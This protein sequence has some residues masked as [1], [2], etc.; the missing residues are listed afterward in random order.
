MSQQHEPLPRSAVQRPALPTDPSALPALP[1]AYHETLAAGLDELSIGLSPEQLGSLEGHVRLLLAWTAA[2]NLTAIREPVAVAREHLL[3]SLTAVPLLAGIGATSMLDLGSGGGA[4]G[5]PLAIAVPAS[6]VLLV[7]SV[8]KKAAFL[9][10][11]TAALGLDSRVGVA[12]ER[13]EAIAVDGRERGR[14]QV[15]LARAVASLG[16]L[17][18]LSFPL[19]VPG[20]HLVAWKRGDLGAEL[21]GARSAAAAL[22][23]GEL[24]VREVGLAALSDHRLVVARRSGRVPRRFPRP[25]AERAAKGW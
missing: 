7:E 9:R 5:I 13:A 19:L 25:P 3:D 8:G 22:G 2:I 11:A 24:E 16:D 4:P 6:R 1:S 20:G 17:V 21:A 12:A 23:G 14:W 15:V 18:E 10:A